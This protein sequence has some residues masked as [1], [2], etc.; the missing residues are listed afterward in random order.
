M[1]NFYDFIQVYVFTPNHHLNVDNGRQDHVL[2]TK[3]EETV[4]RQTT[5]MQGMK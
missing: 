2:I 4:Y 1:L 5:Y 3:T